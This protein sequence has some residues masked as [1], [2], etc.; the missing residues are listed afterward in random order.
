MWNGLRNNENITK[1]L[2]SYQFELDIKLKKIIQFKVFC[3]VK[4]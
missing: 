3:L 2:E 4:T 1:G